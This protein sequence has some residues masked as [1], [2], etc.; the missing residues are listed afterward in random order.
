MGF[1]VCVNTVP[2]IHSFH[3]TYPNQRSQTT[4]TLS[5]FHHRSG[6]SSFDDLPLSG[7]EY[8]NDNHLRRPG[9]RILRMNDPRNG[10]DSR[11]L[12]NPPNNQI[13][14]SN[15]QN[16]GLERENDPTNPGL[17]PHADITGSGNGTVRNGPHYTFDDSAL[18]SFLTARDKRLLTDMTDRNAGVHKVLA[19]LRSEVGDLKIQICAI[20]CQVEILVL[21]HN[22]NIASSG[23]FLGGRRDVASRCD[24]LLPH[25]S[26][27][28]KSTV[29][30]NVVI[31]S[32]IHMVSMSSEVCNDH[33]VAFGK[34]S[35]ESIWTTAYYTVDAILFGK[36]ATM[37][38]EVLLSGS[39]KEYSKLRK[40]LVMS[41]IF[42]V[43][44][45]RF[46]QFQLDCNQN[47]GSSIGSDAGSTG[48]V[49]SR[50]WGEVGTNSVSHSGKITQ[51]S[52]IKSRVITSA[53][54]EKGRCRVEMR[55]ERNKPAVSKKRKLDGR[56]TDD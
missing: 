21:K 43:Q 12:V 33:V 50:I 32:V 27:V 1:L 44:H 48:G 42:N 25:L 28:F 49:P 26:L 45:N 52:G 53:H 24:A 46:R 6:V 39:G 10:R 17:V 23:G 7:M 22:E 20:K 38:R 55:N 9:S 51:P 31:A 15:S 37:K 56:P 35:V 18:R 19:D 3:F 4:P 36:K 8:R 29:F 11:A 40:L 34:C 30:S 47:G 16:G 14:P 54:V 13:G 5:T 41:L 2:S